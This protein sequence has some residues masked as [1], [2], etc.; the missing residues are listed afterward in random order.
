V[1]PSEKAGVSYLSVDGQDHCVVFGAERC[2][3]HGLSRDGAVIGHG[4]LQSNPTTP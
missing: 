1:K 3:A 2:L 4:N